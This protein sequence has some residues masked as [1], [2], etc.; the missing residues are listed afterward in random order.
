MMVSVK[1]LKFTLGFGYDHD[2][3]VL[4]RMCHALVKIVLECTIL[5]SPLISFY[6]NNLHMI[7]IKYELV[8]T[9]FMRY[10][11]TKSKRG[12]VN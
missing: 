2:K 11:I 6:N 9:L 4:I 12:F 7:I 8:E 1:R 3:H 10:F 5:S